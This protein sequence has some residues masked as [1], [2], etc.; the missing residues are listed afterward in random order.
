MVETQSLHKGRGHV[1]DRGIVL[2]SRIRVYII[3][4]ENMC[5]TIPYYTMLSRIGGSVSWVAQIEKNSKYPG[6]LNIQNSTSTHMGGFQNYGP[7]WS[8]S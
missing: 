3:F 8:P 7:F 5:H 1:F 6:P 2:E 4:Y